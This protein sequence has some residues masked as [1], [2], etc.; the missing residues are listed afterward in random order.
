M[1]YNP[2]NQQLPHVYVDKEMQ[3]MQTMLFDMIQ[4]QVQNKFDTYVYL[5]S[6][7]AGDKCR[8]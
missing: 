5:I 2:A 4:T 1:D 7:K 8:G 3:K 6:S